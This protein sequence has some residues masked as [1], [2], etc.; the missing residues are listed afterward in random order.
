[1]KGPFLL[2]NHLVVRPVLREKIKM[3][4]TVTGVALGV[5]VF[6]SIRLANL[7]IL[8]SFK[9]SLES[10]SGRATLEVSA[11]EAGFDELVLPIVREEEGIQRLTPVVQATALVAGTKGEALLVLGV[12]VLGD[13]PFRDYKT[14][15]DAVETGSSRPYVDSLMDLL[16][17]PQAVVLTRKFAEAHGFT[18]G[19][20]LKLA[21]DEKVLEFKVKALLEQEG[22]AKAQSGHVAIMDIAAAQVAFNKV[23]KLDRIDLIVEDSKIPEVIEGLR[24]KLPPHLTVE[25]PQTRNLQVQKMLNSFQQNL[26]ALS[27]IALLVGMFLIYNTLSISVVRRRKE[28]GTLR[29]VGVTRGQ[30]RLFFVL[31][32]I[33]IGFLGSLL[34]LLLALLL[35]RGALETMATTVSSLYI[36]VHVERITWTP[37]ILVEGLLLGILVSV[38]S[39]LVPVIEASQVPPKEA[40]QE[41]AYPLK[42]PSGYWKISLIGGFLL[43]L[44]YLAA[45]QKPPLEDLT[46]A[47][48]ATPVY[49]YMSALLLVLG[50]AFLTP[51]FTVLFNRLVNPL[52][53]WLLKAEGKLAGNY[54]VQTLGRTTLAITALMTALTMVVGVTIMV[55]SFRKTVEIWIHETVTGDLIVAPISRFTHG[56]EAK[57]PEEFVEELKAMD[58]VAAVDPVRTLKMRYTARDLK[59]S[60]TAPP[61][62]P[63]ADK[64]RRTMAEIVLASGDL[65]VVK[66]YGNLLFLEGDKNKILDQAREKGQALISESFSVK[67]GVNAGDLLTLDSPLGELQI[68][69][70]GVFYSYSTEHGLIVLD[71]R[72]FKKYWGDPFVNS[73][74]VYLKPEADLEKVR[75]EI[76]N[77]FGETHNMTVITNRTLKENILEIFDQTFA[78]TSALELI[79]ILVAILGITNALLASMLER[80]REIGV[81]RAVGA[82]GSQVMR[83]ILYEAGLMGI[84]SHLLSLITGLF[85]SFIL[86]Y[87]INKQSF[88]WT[89]QFFF[90][91]FLIPKSL[92]IVLVT[93]MLAGYF[94]ARRAVKLQVVDAL[95]YE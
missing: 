82:T 67:Y 38:L 3:L 49:G 9:T 42:K 41:G 75:G 91:L 89:I 28:I 83:V 1:M 88:G 6:L 47:P 69:V 40:L 36:P 64:G 66:E 27:T 43:G 73:F 76:L 60:P 93:S 7:S 20:T 57:V 65:R 50:V 46:R 77:R 16:W 12:D 29:A 81:L 85:L 84:I 31:E 21:V 39:A 59:G 78:I 33:F 2:L 15:D 62:Q 55:S 8:D 44:A 14:S 4:L 54:L 48:D 56:A 24:A 17:D 71:R 18:V 63:P 53:T 13:A 37:E 45:L 87:V 86:I 32:A 61:P 25:R 30:I 23:G 10:V 51:A 90:P 72:L 95:Q 70:A 52:L 5:A 19:S 74:T 92:L 11:G 34:G 22:L 26:T 79:A 35:A 58:G 68:P 94:P 80:K